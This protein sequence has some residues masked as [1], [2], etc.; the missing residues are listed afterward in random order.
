MALLGELSRKQHSWRR[1]VWEALR[2]AQG[3]GGSGALDC[4]LRIAEEVKG[5]EPEQL[6]VVVSRLE[7]K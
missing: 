2:A 5:G 1:S 4:G 6:S 7:P 3:I